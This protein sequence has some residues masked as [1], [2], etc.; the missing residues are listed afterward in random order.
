MQNK[1]VYPRKFTEKSSLTFLKTKKTISRRHRERE[2][3]SIYKWAFQ[4]SL[5]TKLI[6]YGLRFWDVMQCESL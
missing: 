5:L 1:H 2:L 4:T 6:L 3:I